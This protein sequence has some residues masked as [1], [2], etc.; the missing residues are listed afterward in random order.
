M[1]FENRFT[2]RAER[3]LRLAHERAAELGHGYV[4]SEHLLFALVSECDGMAGKVLK[5]AGVEAES[6]R[7][8]I[9]ETV[10]LGTAGKR[11]PQGLTPR[12]K[13]IVE[14]SYAEATRM[15]NRYVGTEH[16]LLGIL[17]EPESVAARLLL[18][19]DVDPAKLY[20]EITNTN[21]PGKPKPPAPEPR[22]APPELKTLSQFGRDLTE[23]AQ[24]GK[25][26]PVIGRE[27]EIARMIQILS[28]RTKNNPVLVGEP[29]VGKTAVAEGLAL[30]IISGNVPQPLRNK[31]IFMLDVPGMIAGTKYRG[32]FEERLKTAIREVSS[33][34]QVILFLDELHTIVGAGS[35]EGAVD[36][37]NILKPALSRGEI[38]VIGATTTNEYRKYIE[39]DAAL[40][41]RFQAITV[42]EPTQEET[43]QILEGLRDRYEAHHGIS[44]TDGALRAAVELSVR[45][46]NDRQLPDKAIDLMDEAASRVRLFTQTPP[47]NV[48]RMEK[49][50]ERLGREKEEKVRAQEFEQAARIRDEEIRLRGEL[51]EIRKRWTSGSSKNGEAVTA[52]HIAAVVAAQTGIPVSRMTESESARILRME[53]MLHQR[54]VGQ[55][56]AVEAVARAVRRGRVGLKDPK[57]PIGSFLF[58]GPTGVGKT[59]LARALAEALFGDENSM[60]RVDMSEYME[61]HA[62]SR[63]IGAPPGYVGHDEG[64]QLT[65]KVRRKPYSVVLFDE[66]EKAH[67]D[68]FHL[69]LQ[70][71]EDGVLTDA[72]GRRVDFRNTVLVMT[73]NVG[74]RNITEEN[75]LGFVSAP[76]AHS[77]VSSHVMAELKRSFRPEFLN[78]IDECIVFHKL[79]HEECREIARKLFQ[80]VA[81]RVAKLNVTLVATEAALDTLA[82]RGFDATNG[83]RPLR[84]LIS[85]WVEDVVAEGILRGEFSAGDTLCVDAA[86]EELSVKKKDD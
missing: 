2:S 66:L 20:Q 9:C 24:C 7:E 57:R 63:L 62:V 77:E 46:L 41:R 36:A 32:E 59:E 4:G 47:Q 64:G 81:E 73:S 40:A 37:A 1:L 72:Q 8:K 53:E 30:R 11:T 60:I 38:Q 70:V 84:R 22:T 52:E 51:T 44:L 27:D 39:S 14:L 17:R 23:L 18:A 49:E 79:T 78:R 67:P 15:G 76:M 50:I 61:R 54:V 56:E 80:T 45:Y 74:A 5:N 55:D 29:G 42:G 6:L 13:R 33:G 85:R 25:L 83:A 12:A 35:A 16:L 10:G 43:I 26:D 69:L 71:L 58:L 31:K 75:R 28:R 48:K 34:G 21:Q 86:E 3:V 68:V 82:R 19:L 65:E